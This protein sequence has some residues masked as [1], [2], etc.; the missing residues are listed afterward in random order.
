MNRMLRGT[1]LP[2]LAWLLAFVA[3]AAGATDPSSGAAISG[4]LVAVSPSV[5]RGRALPGQPDVFST[6]GPITLLAASD[7]RVAVR[8]KTKG[9][10]GRVVVGTVPSRSSTSFKD[11]CFGDGVDELALGGGQVAWIG[12]DGGNNLE[13]TVIA[14]KLS[15]GASK[16][17]DYAVNGD[18]AGGDPSGGWVGQLFG[19][20]PLLA[21]NSWTVVCNPPPGYSC[22]EQ[23]PTLQVTHEKL[24][25]IPAGRRVVVG[26]GARSYPLS[27]VGGGRMAVES[28]GVVT[29]LAASGAPLTSVPAVEG[30]PPR[31]VALSRS[32]LALKRTF[33]LDLYDPAT[34]AVTKSLPLGSMA[35]LRLAG[36]SS[37]LA[38]LVSP[39][40]LVLVRLRDGKLISLPLGPVVKRGFVDA[41]LTEA[42]LFY[43][44]NLTRAAARGRVVF[45]PSAKLLAFF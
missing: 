35:A 15:G 20:G 7:N 45:M 36:V 21:Y 4:S 16:Q 14:A 22:S 9:A 1:T 43:A 28:A 33:T 11:G 34:G 37:K 42:G 19:G 10:C 32:R 44:Y 24:V 12:Q 25:G 23:D 27:A 8:A 30:N 38:L 18:R 2:L 39:R 31:T 5:A 41:R 26:R 6:R 13:L 17:I 3:G 29:V 40:R